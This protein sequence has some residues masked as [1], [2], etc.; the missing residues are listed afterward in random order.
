MQ[1]GS[2]AAE[3]A[4][5]S[6]TAAAAAAPVKALLIQLF[7]G[8]SGAG[9]GGAAGQKT[10]VIKFALPFLAFPLHFFVVALLFGVVHPAVQ[11]L[12]SLPFRVVFS[13]FRCCPRCAFPNNRAQ[14]GLNLTEASLV[15]LLEP[16]LHP[17]LEE[18][19]VGRIHRL[20]QTRPT[21]VVRCGGPAFP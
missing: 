8:S 12:F 5:G 16:T 9:G 7:G 6:R 21:R 13:A 3:G 2:A 10:L 1:T 15:V 18:Q 11:C 19:A 17:G 14:T 20:G 4:G